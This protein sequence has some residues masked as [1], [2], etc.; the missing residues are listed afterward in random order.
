ML[1]DSEL[2]IKKGSI[3]KSQLIEQFFTRLGTG[4][5]LCKLCQGT[6]Q[7]QNV[8]IILTSNA[9]IEQSVPTQQTLY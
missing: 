9:R 2:V 7:E 3:G 4:G 5:F 6:N 8:K 1:L